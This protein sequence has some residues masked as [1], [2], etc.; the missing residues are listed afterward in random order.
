MTYLVLSSSSLGYTCY[1][2]V[3]KSLRIAKKRGNIQKVLIGDRVSVDEEGFI[4]KVEE[5]KAVLYRPRLANPD[6]V[7]IVLSATKPRFSTYLA[8]KFLTVINYC[9][10]KA[11]LIVTKIDLLTESEKA[12]LEKTLDFYRG[13][14]YNVF[15]LDAKDKEKY[16]FPKLLEF[17]KGKKVALM[18]QTGVGKSTILNSINPDIKRKVDSL[19]AKVERGRHVT[20]ESILI[21]FDDFMIYDTPGFS[22]FNLDMMNKEELAVFFPG[23]STLFLKCEFVDCHH[24]R[25]MKGCHVLEEVSKNAYPLENYQ[26][27]C[28]IYTEVKSGWKRK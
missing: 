11:S 26:N 27:Y 22:S 4:Y 16:D 19:Y 24:L 6:Y 21:P 9:E 7:Y 12:E 23:F 25:G 14:N 15:L 20:K 1:S 2:E 28:K 18:G 5:E 10:I 13:L 17:T 3:D 8:D